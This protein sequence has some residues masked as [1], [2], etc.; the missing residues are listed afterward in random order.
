MVTPR[1]E[2][3]ARKM[4]K[5]AIEANGISQGSSVLVVQDKK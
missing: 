1:T 2:F 5:R 3:N 4:M